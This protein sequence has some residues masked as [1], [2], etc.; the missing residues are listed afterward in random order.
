[1]PFELTSPAGREVAVYCANHLAN[2][3][4]STPAYSHGNLEQALKDG[5]M[6]CDRIVMQD[7]AIQEMKTYDEDE[8]PVEE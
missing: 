5:F 1:M 8:I 4:K 6:Q 7:K 2:I 3:I